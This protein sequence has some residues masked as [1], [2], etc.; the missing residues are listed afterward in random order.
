MRSTDS[1]LFPVLAPDDEHLGR[2]KNSDNVPNLLGRDVENIQVF[3]PNFAWT[4]SFEHSVDKFR[5]AA[6]AIRRSWS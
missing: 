5:A 6:R 1:I 4:S 3:P 2:D